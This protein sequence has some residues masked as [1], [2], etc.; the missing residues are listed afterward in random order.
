MQTKREANG[1]E[2]IGVTLPNAGTLMEAQ[3]A[4]AENATR[5]ANAASHYALSVN[6]IWLELWGNRL[7]KY[8]QF[9]KRFVDVQ[10]DFMKEAFDHYQESVQ[11]LAKLSAK[12]T[13]DAQS[14][15]WERNCRL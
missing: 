5:I 2:E 4:A 6:K 3:R 12:A 1:A 10:T 15:A 13:Q 9:P 11:K 7:D 8:L 14:A